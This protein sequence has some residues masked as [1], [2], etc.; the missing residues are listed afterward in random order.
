[1]RSL[2]FSRV[3]WTLAKWGLE[4]MIEEA[5][6]QGLEALAIGVMG[7]TVLC[8]AGALLVIGSRA[9][10]RKLD[11]R[12][13]AQRVRPERAESVDLGAAIRG[14]DLEACRKGRAA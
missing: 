2:R 10:V 7:A 14:D 13:E 9:L 1:M 4:R 3:L 6:F 5:I 8:V 11:R 12:V